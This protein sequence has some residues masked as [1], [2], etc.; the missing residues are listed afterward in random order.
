MEFPNSLSRNVAQEG[1]TLIL[2]DNFSH[3][4]RSQRCPVRMPS[5]SILTEGERFD[6]V[7][8]LSWLWGDFAPFDSNTGCLSVDPELVI[9]MLLV[10][11]CHSVRSE[12]P[13]CQHV[14]LNLAYWWWFSAGSALRISSQR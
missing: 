5:T 13:L 2:R 14:E 6:A 1:P 9:R 12:R 7:L 8:D 3:V 10:G 4:C 11:Y